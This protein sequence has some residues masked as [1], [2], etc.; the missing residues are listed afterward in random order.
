[1]N[2]KKVRKFALILATA[3]LIIGISIYV[4]LVFPGEEKS[5]IKK[6]NLEKGMVTFIFDDVHSTFYDNAF[7]VFKEKGFSGSVAIDILRWQL[8]RGD[9]MTK[10]EVKELQESGWEIMSHSVTHKKFEDSSRLR[11][12]LEI[13]LSKTYL[14][15]MGFEVKQYVAP[16]STYPEKQF[17]LLKRFYDA[18]YTEYVD[19]KKEPVNSLVIENEADI[20]KFHR[21]NMQGKTIEEL[22]DYIDYVE[23]N[24]SW[25]VLYEHQIGGEG[26]YT[27]T[28]TLKELLDYI[29]TKN[30][31]VLTGSE[32]LSRLN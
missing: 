28:E 23:E 5:I 24:D 7:P 15:L 13:A 9:L 6:V 27:K 10:N 16:M 19:S 32:A 22:K 11:V 21:A 4:Y 18:G 8:N 2:W 1:V 12:S 30:V 31:N 29:E 14:E 26:E 17:D 20:Y 25:L 3:C